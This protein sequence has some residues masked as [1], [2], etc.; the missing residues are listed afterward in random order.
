MI[1]AHPVTLHSIKTNALIAFDVSSDVVPQ[2]VTI[3]GFREL[4]PILDKP[5]FGWLAK[6]MNAQFDLISGSLDCL[7]T[8]YH[9]EK[10][11][12]FA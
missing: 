6:H 7:L 12:Y 10:V 5:T 4:I 2:S 1:Q 11:D 8:F 3:S 9:L